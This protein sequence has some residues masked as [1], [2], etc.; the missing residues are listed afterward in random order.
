MRRDDRCGSNVKLSFFAL[1]AT[2]K[3]LKTSRTAA[4]ND[5]GNENALLLDSVD[6]AEVVSEALSDVFSGTTR[7]ISGCSG[8]V[9]A[10]DQTSWRAISSSASLL[11][12]EGRRLLFLRVPGRD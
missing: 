3:G 4:V 7:P 1:D 11:P 2:S 10:G 8:I 6:D 5:R 12:D 9:S